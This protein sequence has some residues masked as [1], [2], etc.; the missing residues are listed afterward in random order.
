LI[1]GQAVD[2]KHRVLGHNVWFRPQSVLLTD[3]AR[4]W[5]IIKIACA[6]RKKPE[7][8]VTIAAEIP[9]FVNA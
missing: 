9:L 7:I 2:E 5:W 3:R 8:V 1:S 4:F 6:K